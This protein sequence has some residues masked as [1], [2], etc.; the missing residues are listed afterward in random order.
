MSWGPSLAARDFVLSRTRGCGHT[1]TRAARTCT[2]LLKRTGLK[3]EISSSTV[4]AAGP[5]GKA[6]ELQQAMFRQ[7]LSECEELPSFTKRSYPCW[8]LSLTNLCELDE[9]PEHEDVIEKLE[10]L[11]V[12]SS[13]D[14]A[15][16]DLVSQPLRGTVGAT[17]QTDSTSPSCAYSFFISQNW[18]GGRVG[19]QSVR[20]PQPGYSVRNRPHPDNALNT[21]ARHD[22]MRQCRT[23]GER[24]LRRDC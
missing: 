10:E 11:Q 9:L 14:G 4:E 19:T 20:N 6:A 23:Q 1:P 21:K 16:Q 12:G 2:Q 18:E 24:S 17:P 7:A 13:D 15:R 22:R 8:V 3:L 5:V